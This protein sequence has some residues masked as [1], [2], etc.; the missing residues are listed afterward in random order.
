M[1]S[2][3]RRSR[4]AVFALTGLMVSLIVGGVDGA[5][6]RLRTAVSKMAP[7]GAQ[8]AVV[9]HDGTQDFALV[10]ELRSVHFD[11]DKAQMRSAQAEALKADAEWIKANPTQPIRVAAYADERGSRA[12]NQALAE[13]RAEAVRGQLVA[14]GV[15]AERI[16]IVAFGEARPCTPMTA[17]CLAANR[18]ADILVAR[19]V[20]QRP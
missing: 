20:D 14:N 2:R 9:P 7:Q 6:S 11:T 17:S 4:F 8:P 10:P 1:T 15:Q 16:S 5:Q 12:Y 13:R 18:R 3:M 19:V